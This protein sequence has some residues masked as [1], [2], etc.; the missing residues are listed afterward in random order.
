MAISIVEISAEE[1][2]RLLL[3]QEG[4][5][6][7][8]KSKDIAPAKLTRTIAALANADG[9][10][11]FVGIVEDKTTGKSTWN[12]FHDTEAANGHIQ[13][14]EALF[15]LGDGFGYSLLTARNKSGLLLR[16]EVSK[17]RDIKRASDGTVYVRRGAQN[18]PVKDE[19]ALATLK[20]AK[21][22][23]TFETETLTQIRA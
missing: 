22:L 9:G 8:L 19:Q 4:H 7:D 17:S 6:A 18:L 23:T 5:F 14:F 16:I 15:P 10:E 20:R 1:A 13:A 11:V 3:T 21:G 2:K 12:G